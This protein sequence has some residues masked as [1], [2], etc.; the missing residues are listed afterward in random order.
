MKMVIIASS[1]RVGSSLISELL[2]Q[3][4]AGY[5]A[6]HFNL[7]VHVPRVAKENNLKTLKQHFEFI[8]QNYSNN[9]K[10]IFTVKC[11]FDQFFNYSNKIDIFSPFEKTEFI[12]IK[13]RSSLDQA[14]SYFLAKATNTWS[15]NKIKDTKSHNKKVLKALQNESAEKLYQEIVRMEFRLTQNEAYWDFYLKNQR[16]HTF[17]YED[18]LTV[19]GMHEAEDVFSK[20]Y[21][22]NIK[23][24]HDK[25]SLKIQRDNEITMFLKDKIAPYTKKPPHIALFDS[26][27]K[28]NNNFYGYGKV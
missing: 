11:H 23:I 10:S 12:Q 22:K 27:L 13:R 1:P 21:Q 14:I 18:L 16:H 15:T 6:E 25:S 26:C 28:F 5:V 17:Y 24:N 8:T 4:D 9:E 3:A 7:S 20:I 19:E 2:T